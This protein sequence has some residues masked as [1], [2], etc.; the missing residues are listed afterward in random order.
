MHPK[1]CS[2]GVLFVLALLALPGM[3]RAQAAPKVRATAG[4]RLFARAYDS[5]IGRAHV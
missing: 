1:T 2:K 4:F 5:Q 3:A